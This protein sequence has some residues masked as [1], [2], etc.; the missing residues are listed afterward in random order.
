MVE[1]PEAEASENH[2]RGQVDGALIAFG[3]CSRDYCRCQSYKPILEQCDGDQVFSPAFQSCV[4]I[5]KVRTG[6]VRPSSLLSPQHTPRP[7]GAAWRRM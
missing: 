3:P 5:S 1:E 7:L 6:L 4:L 2:C